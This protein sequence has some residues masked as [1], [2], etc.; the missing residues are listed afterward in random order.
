MDRGSWR[1]EL[2][3]VIAGTVLPVGGAVRVVIVALVFW[4]VAGFA[5]VVAVGGGLWYRAYPR[6]SPEARPSTARADRALHLGGTAAFALVAAGLV[7]ADVGFVS[8][9]GGVAALAGGSEAGSWYAGLSWLS[10]YPLMDAG[11]VLAYGG[12]A[13]GIALAGLATVDGVRDR[14]R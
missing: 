9:I 10:P 8:T 11:A 14:L 4:L 12:V 5:L 6:R 3:L 7:V 1:R 13:A 2:R